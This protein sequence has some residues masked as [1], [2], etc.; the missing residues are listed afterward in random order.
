MEE[1][2]DDKIQRLKNE[3][4]MAKQAH[5]LW[6]MLIQKRE[7]LEDKIASLKNEIEDEKMKQYEKAH[8]VYEEAKAGGNK[9]ET[10]DSIKQSKQTIDNKLDDYEDI[11]G[12]ILVYLQNQLV[13]TILKKFPDQEL[14]FQ[15]LDRQLYRS[16]DISEKLNT[17]QVS[18][19]EIDE[20]ISK[21]FIER[22]KSKP[23][24][25]LSF[26][27][28][29]N[30]NYQITQHIKAVKLL[31]GHSLDLLH[32][33]AELVQ[34]NQRAQSCLEQLSELFVKLQ[35]FAQQ[36]WSYNKIDN[37]LLPL[38]DTFKSYVDQLLVLKKEA[39]ENTDSQQEM[40][41]LWI[42]QHT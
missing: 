28:G 30:P 10:L 14:S 29:N 18:T 26:F 2:L 39:E 13:I 8:D 21:I 22:E 15:N 35:T 31:C 12:D 42:E 4:A 9:K 5:Q 17:L 1:S 36:R 34:D 40:I 38:K 6:D 33:L 3:L 25:I 32:D 19:K 27:F 20:L 24:R 37:E 11:S 23:L 41:N 16:I 7:Q